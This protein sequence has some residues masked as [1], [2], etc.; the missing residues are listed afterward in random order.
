MTSRV[1]AAR[2]LDSNVIEVDCEA[3]D[4]RFQQYDTISIISE[5]TTNDA[6]GDCDQLEGAAVEMP[7]QVDRIASPVAADHDTSHS[8]LPQ[9]FGKKSESFVVGPTLMFREADSFSSGRGD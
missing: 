4:S 6:P 3:E 1:N 7:L 2:Q 5:T 8:P 9:A